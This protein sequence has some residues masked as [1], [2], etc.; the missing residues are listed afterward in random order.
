MKLKNMT[1]FTVSSV[2][3]FA[4][5]AGAQTGTVV[6][7]RTSAQTQAPVHKTKPALKKKPG[8][9]TI[10]TKP[11]AVIKKV[12]SEPAGVKANRGRPP[13]NVVPPTAVATPFDE[14]VAKLSAAEPG[15]RR[16]GADSLSQ[17]R[18]PRGMPYLIAAL[19]DEN[20]QVR[21][22]AVDGLGMLSAIEAAP[23]LAEMLT[24]DKEPTVRQAVAISLSYIMA[25]TS[26]PALLKALNDTSTAVKYAAAHTLGAM[27]YAPAE[28]Q[29]ISM[30]ADTDAGSR[31]VA[32]AALGDLQSKKAEQTVIKMLADNDKYI[33]LEAVRAL[34]NIGDKSA[35]DELKKNLNPNEDPAVR[36]ET[37]LALS[38]MDDKSGLD[39][40]YEFA[41]SS[42]LSL[43]SQALNV[44]GN[45]GDEHSLG[46]IEEMFAAEKDPTSKGMLDF[47]RQRLIARLTPPAK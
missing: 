38:K 26:G 17:S 3:A 32:I 20:A 31:R 15:V 37:A 8:V 6:S 46:F 16:Q 41:K 42:D 47:I 40:A 25:P 14:A 39:T 21:V 29:L 12:T 23:Q 1:G 2:F 33:R 18:D 13:A 34:G 43:K 5:L 27:K 19:K 9:Q 35:L 45:I 22:A 28:D 44:I 11:A 30:L 36:V 7:T 4:I 10:Q 24:T